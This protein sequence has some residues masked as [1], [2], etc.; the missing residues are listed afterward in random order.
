MA[1]E[2]KERLH[3]AINALP[4]P[5][6]ELIEA[7]YFNET[8]TEDYAKRIGITVRGVNKRWKNALA[9]LRAI[10]NLLGSF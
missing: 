1:N 9:K 8:S 2:I 10:W 5:K 4:K 7:L 6:K 3:R